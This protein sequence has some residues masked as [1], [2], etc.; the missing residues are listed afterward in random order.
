MRGGWAEDGLTW[1][2]PCPRSTAL[3]SSTGGV[4]DKVPKTAALRFHSRIT[5]ALESTPFNTAAD[6]LNPEARHVSDSRHSQLQSV[7]RRPLKEGIPQ[8]ILTSTNLF[9]LFDCSLDCL[10]LAVFP[11]TGGVLS[12][13]GD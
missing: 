6:F 12:P 4:V 10:N 11:H 8:T 13:H 7:K 2:G 1:I 3:L 9:S 5:G